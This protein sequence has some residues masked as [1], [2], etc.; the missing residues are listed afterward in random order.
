MKTSKSS[1]IAI[2]AIAMLT[3]PFHGF[4]QTYNLTEPVTLGIIVNTS[5][6]LAMHPNDELNVGTINESVVIN[7]T[8]ETIAVSG[9]FTP[10]L[11]ATAIDL[12]SGVQVTSPGVFPN[13]PTSVYVPIDLTLSF[14]S[15]ADQPVSFNSGATALVWNGSA[16][17]FDGTSSFGA[18]TLISSPL[19]LSYSYSLNGETYTGSESG[20]FVID[21]VGVQEQSLL[22]LTNY[23]TSIGLD[24][25]P[26]IV[27]SGYSETSLNFDG[28][29]GYTGEVFVAIPE[30]STYAAIL[31]LLTVGFVA[32]RKMRWLE[33]GLTTLSVIV[34]GLDLP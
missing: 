24:Q 20:H 29:D 17:G 19:N 4:G 9:S 3:Q 31:A 28:P 27:T 14:G 30:P 11:T 22:N 25:N 7:P 16:W 23:P 1:L 18:A 8:A 26:S 6:D 10:S 2:L 12:G 15:S 32:I 33:F 13:P 34:F 5:G 21:A